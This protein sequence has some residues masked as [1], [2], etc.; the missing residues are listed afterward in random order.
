MAGARILV[1]DA[2]P[3]VR[4]LL[5]NCLSEQGFDI[6]LATSGEEA[7]A[8]LDRWPPDVLLLDLELP[9]LSGLDVCQTVRRWSCLPIIALSVDSAE[10]DKVHALDLGADDYLTKP[11][12]LEE[13]SARV[14]VALRHAAG[15]TIR[16]E[17]LLGDGEIRIDFRERRVWRGEAEIQLTPREYDL[18]KYLVQ[19]RDRDLYFGEVVRGVWG[20]RRAGGR[21]L[22]R[23]IPHLRNK[24]EADPSQPRYLLSYPGSAIRLCSAG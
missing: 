10:L 4:R 17:V 21:Y 11:F 13:L 23:Y 14:R 9:G 19:H 16:P 20:M 15:G 6:R 8:T 18:L 24:L 12:G 22:R 3:G 5:R 2:E 1:A 7:L